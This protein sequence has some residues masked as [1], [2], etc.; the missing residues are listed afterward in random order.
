MSAAELDEFLSRPLIARLATSRGGQP[1][2]LP[3]WFLWDGSVVWM[4]TSPTFAN[5]RIL[6]ENPRAAL[7]IDE[8]L[9]GL[10]LRAAAMEG[11]VDVIDAPVA[12]VLGMVRRI[13]ARYLSSDELDRD[14]AA[15][16]NETRHVLL[17]FEPSK[18]RT[19]DTTA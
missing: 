8:S 4:E 9:G 11:R 17:R 1:R 12:D 7:V 16:L 5:A 10:R 18:V 2:V 14:G 19:W 6:R 13:Y 15:M 3:M